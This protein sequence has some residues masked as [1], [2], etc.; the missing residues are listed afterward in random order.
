M[1]RESASC[2]C[3]HCKKSFRML[4]DEVACAEC[5]N[6]GYHG[7][8]DDEEP[9]VHTHVCEQCG[10]RWDCTDVCNLTCPKC[11]KDLVM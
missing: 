6:C 4:D 11:G 7:H 8:D 3:P 10:Q 2:R 5:P 1:E 9:D